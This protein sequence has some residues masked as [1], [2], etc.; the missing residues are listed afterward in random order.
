MIFILEL[1]LK[2]AVLAVLSF[3]LCLHFKLQKV[4]K[5][6]FLAFVLAIAC[7]AQLIGTQIPS[8]REPITITALNEMNVDSGNT[9]IMISGF[10]VDGKEYDVGRPLNGKWF[11][12]GTNYMWRNEQDSRQPDGT[13]A[14]V[15]LG[16]PVGQERTIKFTA[17]QWNGLAEVE[18]GGESQIID[19]YAVN[20]QEQTIQ[21]S[22]STSTAILTQVLKSVF[23]FCLILLLWCAATYWVLRYRQ[24]HTQQFISYIAH[25]RFHFCLLAVSAIMFAVMV[26]FSADS[27][28]WNDEIYQIA[29]SIENESVLQ[30]LFST[31]ISYYPSLFDA[32]CAFWYRIAP[33]GERWLLLP[34]EVVT[35]AGVFFLG[36]AA[37]QIYEKRTALLTAVLAA[38]ST[39]LIFQGGY[40]FR[41]YGFLFCCC[42][43]CLWVYCKCRKNLDV[44]WKRLL[45]LGIALWLPTAFHVFGVFFSAGLV[46]TDTVYML[47]KKLSFKWLYAYC[48]SGFLYIPWLYNMICYDAMG[49][50]ATWQETPSVAAVI[51]LLRYLSND[52]ALYFILFLIGI[53]W[54]F[55]RLYSCE[56]VKETVSILHL[57]PL[58]TLCFVITFVYFY[59]VYIS[60]TA[61]MWM[62]RYFIVLFPCVILL[63]GLGA[64]AICVALARKETVCILCAAIIANNM[65]ESCQRLN[66]PS[67][68]SYQQFAEAADWFYAQQNT[69]YNNDTVIVYAPDAPYFAWQEYYATKQGLRDPL[70]I[71]SQ[72]TLA[73]DQIEDKSVVYVY[74]EHI[75]MFDTTR[76][77][78]EKGGLSETAND[79]YRKICTFER[80]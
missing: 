27:D 67:P 64:N 32:V 8:M 57:A 23:I 30:Q 36:L 2:L 61:T 77:I 48:I 33:Y 46:L 51:S 68:T 31:H 17:G 74:Y 62:H 22:N 75:G 56:R 3:F 50:E 45:L 35:A 60:P 15:T 52:S 29:F 73:P 20:Y 24:G 40:E 63:E 34:T 28:F 26:Y 41:G 65:L 49:I 70:P 6:I 43:F 25:H 80:Q 9:E 69:I 13:T 78:L 12:G 10:R 18:Y 79:D 54:I 37:E 72:W 47:R 16:I 39:N 42:C 1:F 14:S 38:L 55:M 11:W 7:L 19:T 58:V 5:W 4:A 53:A 76:D 66:Q 44:S 71:I 21:I 59:G